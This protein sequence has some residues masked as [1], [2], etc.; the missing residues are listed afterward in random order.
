MIECPKCRKTGNI[1][2]VWNLKT[3]ITKNTCKSCGYKWKI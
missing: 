1:K 2:G 3:N